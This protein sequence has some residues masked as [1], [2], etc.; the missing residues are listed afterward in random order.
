MNGP[1]S[2]ADY[3]EACTRMIRADY[4]G[5]GT[6]F[7]KDGT[8]I[9]MGDGVGVQSFETV[10]RPS[11]AFEAVW[12]PNGAT[13]VSKTRY[14]LTQVP[15]C[16][17]DRLADSCDDMVAATERSGGVVL[18]KPLGERRRLPALTSTT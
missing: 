8:L 9:D 12:G 1:V 3:H 5:D 10:S 11:F 7:T 16:L 15:S 2:L 17:A 6:S 14:P 4:C 18:S 13:C